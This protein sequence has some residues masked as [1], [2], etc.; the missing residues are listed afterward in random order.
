MN[1][2]F[3][4]VRAAY[5]RLFNVLAL[6]F[7]SHG[8]EHIQGT[9]I[10]VMGQRLESMIHEVKQVTSSKSEVTKRVSSMKSVEVNEVLT[11]QE[12]VHEAEM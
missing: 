7:T 11:D 4:G 10:Q 3:E 5:A 2:D 12:S 8:S 1:T 9:E 6:K